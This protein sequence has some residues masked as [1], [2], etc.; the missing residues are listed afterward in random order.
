[1]N[2][3]F[4]PETL[5]AVLVVS[6]S[7]VA[8]ASVYSLVYMGLVFQKVNKVLK[9]YRG[10]IKRLEDTLEFIKNKMDNSAMYLGHLTDGVKDLAGML[11]ISKKK[12]KK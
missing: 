4:Q 7:L 10:I 8:L 2:W 12:R 11:G 9:A 6:I 5:N 3:L 1:M